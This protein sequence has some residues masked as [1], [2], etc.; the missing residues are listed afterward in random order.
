MRRLSDHEWWR[1]SFG[2]PGVTYRFFAVA[3]LPDGGYLAGGEINGPGFGDFHGWLARLDTAGGLLWQ[4]RLDDVGGEIHS[5]AVSSDGG[6]VV[7]GR[8]ES[9]PHMMVARLDAA[10]AVSGCNHAVT[11]ASRL[12]SSGGWT[13]ETRSVIEP[14]TLVVRDTDKPIVDAF[15]PEDRTYCQGGPTYPP[16]EVSPAAAAGDPLLFQDAGTLVWEG[17]APS[18][19]TRFHLYRGDPADLR[20]GGGPACLFAG[21][22]SNRAADPEVPAPG[23]I[24][25]YLAAGENETGRG[26]LGRA[27]DGSLVRPATPCD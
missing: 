26:V 20:S 7:G 25:V 17:A 27:S 19:S 1:A 15:F 4:R 23:E 21:L 18:A 14:T 13:V 6:Y 24:F 8:R 3:P 2:Q 16:S 10:G 5:V 22:T 12:A 11:S 9:F